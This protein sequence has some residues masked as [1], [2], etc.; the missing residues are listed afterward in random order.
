[1]SDNEIKKEKEEFEKK[2]KKKKRELIEQML[3]TLTVE[4]R[5]KMFLFV[6][7]DDLRKST[8]KSSKVANKLF[9]ILIILTGVMAIGTIIG[10]IA[11][12]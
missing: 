11:V 3:G 6:S 9:V 2:L 7:I 10:A 1:M 12:F 4:H 5:L 8:E